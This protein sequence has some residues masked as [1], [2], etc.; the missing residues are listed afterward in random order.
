MTERV[1]GKNMLSTIG[2]EAAILSTFGV[3]GY[4]GQDYFFSGL[5]DIGLGFAFLAGSFKL[6]SGVLDRYAMYR[7]EIERGNRSRWSTIRRMTDR[8]G[9]DLVLTMRTI[10]AVSGGAL[11]H[12]HDRYASLVLTG[13]SLLG[14]TNVVKRLAFVAA[15]NMVIGLNGKYKGLRG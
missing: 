1:T 4:I 12:D 3:G 9:V 10:A 5:A 2:Q 6:E 7:N 11:L 15:D 13:A 14:L 8:R